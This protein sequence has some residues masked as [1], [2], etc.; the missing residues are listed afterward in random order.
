VPSR[1]TSANPREQSDNAPR[2]CGQTARKPELLGIAREIRIAGRIVQDDKRMTAL[3]R[4]SLFAG[5]LRRFN[6]PLVN[7]HILAA[8]TDDPDS[9]AFRKSEALAQINVPGRAFLNLK[10]T[11]FGYTWSGPVT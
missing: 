7:S 1:W 2:D 4:S 11:G 8:P 5:K 3:R 9:C 10:L 6:K